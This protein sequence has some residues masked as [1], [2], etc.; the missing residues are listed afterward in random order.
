MQDSLL[1]I[2]K[3]IAKNRKN[4]RIFDQKLDEKNF[5]IFNFKFNKQINK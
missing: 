2:N 1:M 3:L 5:L 4:Q